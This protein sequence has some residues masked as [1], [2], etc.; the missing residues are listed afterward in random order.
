MPHTI[1]VRTRLRLDVSIGA[2]AWLF[3]MTWTLFPPL[4]HWASLAGANGVLSPTPFKP[5]RRNGPRMWGAGVLWALVSP[6]S[7]SLIYLYFTMRE[8]LVSRWARWK[9]ASLV[10]NWSWDGWV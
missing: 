2:L 1:D 3:R 4:H 9:S 6:R 8:W 7:L 5:R 10:L